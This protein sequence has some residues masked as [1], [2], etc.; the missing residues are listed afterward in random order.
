MFHSLSRHIL[1]FTLPFSVLFS[2][3]GWKIAETLLLGAI[4][5]R[6]KRTVCAVLRSVGLQWESGFSKYH[7]ILNRTK[8]SPL[9]G[10]KI[11]L[12]IILEALA[13]G[14]LVIEVDETLERRKGNKIKAKGIYRDAVRSSKSNVVKTFGLK[15]LVMAVSI[16]FPFARRAFSLPFFT[17]L[18]P[19]KKC[20]QGRKKRHK[21]TIDWTCQMIMQL[22]RWL[23]KMP[24]ILVGDGGFAAGKLAWLCL[25]HNITLV[26]RLKM[27]ARLYAFPDDPPRGKKGRRA[28]K[29]DRLS[30]FKAMLEM[31]D[32]GWKTS[33]ITC[34][35]GKKKWVSYIT[36][37]ALWGA[38]E[39]DPVPFRWVLVIDLEGRLSP[40]PLMSTDPML[41]AER[42][43][44][45]YIDRWNIEVTFEEVREHL[46]VETQ[47]Q[48]SD[49]AIE[50][51]TPILMAL[52]SQ[53]CLA[54][55]RI[56]ETEEIKM[57]GAAWYEKETVTFSDMLRVVRSQLWRDSS[58]CKKAFASTSKEIEQSDKAVLVE[59]LVGCLSR[60]A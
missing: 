36:N 50:R 48:W 21:T 9:Q 46:G 12:R 16:R 60:V 18:Q 25:K 8:W 30:S 40:L 27:N 10:A 55:N 31:K 35:G 23:P 14:A 13:N 2:A 56:N 44:E 5:C 53:I 26:S 6:G 39:F 38:N 33:E 29:G 54:A 20:D 52:Y 58:F 41:S 7:R 4:V 57:E 34:Y 11:L 17:V 3:K 49:K 32:L 22:T 47:R 15:W 51:T 28:T 37:T 42:I 19:S 45:L 59:M 24:F 43:I 1:P